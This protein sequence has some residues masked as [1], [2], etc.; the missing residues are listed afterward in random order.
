[1]YGNAC[2]LE[3]ITDIIVLSRQKRMPIG[4]EMV[5]SLG[6]NQFANANKGKGSVYVCF[7]RGQSETQILNNAG[8]NKGWGE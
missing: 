6:D 7:K 8:A 4:Y 1:M 3:P 5:R 2:D